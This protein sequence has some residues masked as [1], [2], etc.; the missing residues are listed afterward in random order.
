MFVESKLFP[1]RWIR[2]NQ[3]LFIIQSA[4]SHESHVECSIHLFCCCFHLVLVNVNILNHVLWTMTVD[5]KKAFEQKKK[6]FSRFNLLIFSFS[7]EFLF[8][9][10]F[11]V[12]QPNGQT[13]HTHTHTQSDRY[14]AV[15]QSIF[16]LSSRVWYRFRSPGCPT[17]L[18]HILIFIRL[19]P[20]K[21]VTVCSIIHDTLCD[22]PSSNVSNQMLKFNS[23]LKFIY[24][25]RIY[26]IKTE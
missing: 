22:F 18:A 12:C 14:I 9:S 15:I 19:G 25:Q 4:N 23:Y 24:I 2:V 17:H 8:S 7:S 20:Y 6:W 26:N 10:C 13:T 21:T 1:S 11:L 16:Y 3:C 5:K